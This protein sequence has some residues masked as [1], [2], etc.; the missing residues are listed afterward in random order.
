M[1]APLTGPGD[2]LGA[3]GELLRDGRLATLEQFPR[4]VGRYA[5]RVGLEQAAIYLADLRED[6][7]REVTGVGLT[8]GEGGEELPVEGSLAGRA[9][10]LT[11]TLTSP[12]AREGRQRYWVPILDGTRRLGVL[13][14][15]GAGDAAGLLHHLVLVLGIQLAT[16]YPFSDSYAR[17]VR[18]GSMNV[19]AE[20]QW[21]LMPPRAFASDDVVVAAV[22]EPTYAVGGDAFDYAVAADVLHL[23]VFDAMGHDSTAGLTANLAVAACR[24][25]RRQ[26][27]DLATISEHIEEALIEH[28]GHTRYVTGILADLDTS[29][30]ELVWVNRGHHPPVLIRGG[31]WITTLSCP[32]AHP[33]GT[34]LHLPVQVGREQLEPG[35]RLLLFT[36]GV[37]EARGRNGQEFGLTRFTDFIVRS[38]AD[39]LPVPETLRRLMNAI[40]GYHDGKLQDDATVLFCEWRGAARNPRLIGSEPGMPGPAPA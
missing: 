30:G 21:A 29:R 2:V 17:L 1:T 11:R 6:V 19:A 26:G 34:D 10:T 20:M 24:N 33:M 18:S 16:K 35:D 25:Q 8:A 27:A 37:T 32:P 7:L 38:Q 31:R 23:T 9:Y 22:M 12:G 5:G 4:L 28:F 14:A 13:R 40:L 3:V 39:G 36:D 15:D